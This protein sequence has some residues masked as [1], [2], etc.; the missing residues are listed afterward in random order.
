[1]FN[2]ESTRVVLNSS[3]TP[4]TWYDYTPYGNMWRSTIS[5]DAHYRFTGQE[6]DPET[7]LWNYRA[8]LYDSGISRFY[9]CD[10]GGQDF[11]LY[12]HCGR[13]QLYKSGQGWE[14]LM[15]FLFH[16]SNL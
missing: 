6:Y 12:M 7:N 11:S 15:D 3:S 4:V 9:A 1:M 13:N 8:R 16:F 5:E 14:N 10:P 2:Q